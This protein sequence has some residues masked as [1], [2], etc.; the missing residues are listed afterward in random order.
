M[1]SLCLVLFTATVAALFAAA[2]APKSASKK[3]SS[4]TSAKKKGR[5]TG[6]PVAA[7]QSAPTPERYKEIQQAL[8]AKGYL[9]SQP[10]GVWDAETMEAMKQFQQDQ[11]L[12]VTG[13]ISAASLIAL[14]LGPKPT[15]PTTPPADPAVNPS[16]APPVPQ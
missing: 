8:A 4:K 13:K 5:T 3:T 12:S 11:N 10:T 6:R 1:K 9:K 7:R 2:P 14:G 16:A 15:G